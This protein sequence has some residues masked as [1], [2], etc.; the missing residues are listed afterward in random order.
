MF[1]SGRL[2]V[3]DE[4][5]VEW[6]LPN[7]SATSHTDTVVSA[8]MMMATLKR[9]P[10]L[11]LL[12]PHPLTRHCFQLFLPYMYDHLRTSVPDPRR[13]KIRLG[14]ARLDKLTTFGEEP[15]AFATLLRPIL[16]R[17]VGA[18]TNAETGSPQDLDFWGR[19]CHAPPQGSGPTYISG[20]I[21]AFCVWDSEGK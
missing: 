12:T 19:I 20:W 13:P 10:F 7:F 16:S 11:V 2:K 15:K 14:K 8:V 6:I 5:L 17:F 4:S 3:V 21:T 1:H 9:Y 18:F